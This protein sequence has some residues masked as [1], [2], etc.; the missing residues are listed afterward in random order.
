MRYL[1]TRKKCVEEMYDL[2]DKQA[3]GLMEDYQSIKS[4]IDGNMEN[5]INSIELGPF[6]EIMGNY[7]QKYLE[8]YRFF[9]AINQ[10]SF[11][12]L[13]F[14]SKQLERQMEQLFFLNEMST[15]VVKRG[16]SGSSSAGQNR[17]RTPN[18][19]TSTN[20]HDLSADIKLNDCK[21]PPK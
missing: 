7:K 15:N 14:D 6:Q 11:K 8:I 19:L 2:K 4:D 16:K 13:K 3:R 10:E 17:E 1:E 20:E 5:I 9:E 21:S 12:V 18:K